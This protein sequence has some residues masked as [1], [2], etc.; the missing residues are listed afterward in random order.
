MWRL[1]FRTEQ[2]RGLKNYFELRA[3]SRANDRASYGRSAACEVPCVFTQ[4]P[5]KKPGRE[6]TKPISEQVPEPPIDFPASSLY[7]MSR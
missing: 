1:S 7:K 2:R 6:P 4:K 5:S 3:L